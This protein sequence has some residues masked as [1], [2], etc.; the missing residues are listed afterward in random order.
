MDKKEILFLG[1]SL[2]VGDLGYNW[3]KYMKKNP[4]YKYL[5][6]GI[7]GAQIP[8]V[9][10]QIDRLPN[11][12]TNPCCIVLLVG[13]NDLTFS[14]L[15]KE[16]PA[17]SK[18]S[19][20]REQKP[21]I[22]NAEEFVKEFEALILKL[23]QRFPKEFLLGIFNIKQMGEDINNVGSSIKCL[24][25]KVC[26][27]N[28]LLLNLVVKYEFATLL[29]EYTPISN[30]MPVYD[31]KYIGSDDI[32]SILVPQR[33]IKAKLMYLCSL[34]FLSHN[35]IGEMY[36]LYTTCDGSHYNERSGKI[37]EELVEKFV[38]TI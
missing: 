18:F 11:S 30:L 1:S 12:I 6:F 4:R 20:M 13:G 21:P 17:Y 8:T 37:I 3:F 32:N 7:N 26:E 22:A 16:H 14:L 9:L 5:N 33:M 23:K 24:N 36:G 25:H 10:K 2:L 29:D 35:Q 28:N 15:S 19:E 31:K 27:Y 34:G 38:D